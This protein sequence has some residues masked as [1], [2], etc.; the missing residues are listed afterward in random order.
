MYRDEE[1]RGGRMEHRRQS[2]KEEGE[3]ERNYSDGKIVGGKGRVEDGKE[4]LKDEE[5]ASGWRR[6]SKVICLIGS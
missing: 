6:L 5:Y 4:G 2:E 1:E 3:D